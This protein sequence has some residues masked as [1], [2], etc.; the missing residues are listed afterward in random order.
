MDV[1]LAR[2]DA[3]VVE[4]RVLARG[5]KCCLVLFGGEAIVRTLYLWL[6]RR[7]LL[8]EVGFQLAAGR[9]A[10][11][12]FVAIRECIAQANIVHEGKALSLGLVPHA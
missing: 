4:A 11:F 12:L 2:D 9:L 3:V 8:I 10:L 7:P 6:W 5:E 1:M